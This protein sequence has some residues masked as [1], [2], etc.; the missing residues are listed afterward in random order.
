MRKSNLTF[1]CV[2]FFLL[3]LSL[4]IFAQE[5]I[6]LKGTIID[7]KCAEANKANLSTFIKTH[8][9]ECA[10]M[11]ACA[12]SG[13]AIYTN[14]KLL[15]KFD[16]ESCAKVVEFLKKKNSTL[17]VTV[18]AKQVGDE[19]NLVSIEKSPGFMEQ[20]KEKMMEKSKEKVMEKGTEG[21]MKGNKPALPTVP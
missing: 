8:P 11:P 16:K 6:T 15:I 4:S 17:N 2:T 10:M 3:S 18:V 1:L 7:N 12:A 14:E 21:M 19:L 5:N 20:G 9:K 13:Y